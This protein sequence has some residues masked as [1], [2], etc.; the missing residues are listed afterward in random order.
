MLKPSTFA[1][2]A[3]MAEED[4]QFLLSRRLLQVSLLMG[5]V[6]VHASVLATLLPAQQQQP[7]GAAPLLMP[8]AEAALR[9]GCADAAAAAAVL[10]AAPSPPRQLAVAGVPHLLRADLDELLAAREAAAAAAAGMP[11]AAFSARAGLSVRDALFL[12]RRGLFRELDWTGGFGSGA[13]AAALAPGDNEDAGAFAT[14]PTDLVEQLMLV[15]QGDALTPIAKLIGKLDLDLSPDEMATFAAG[16]G[17]HAVTRHGALCFLREDVD[18][19]Y[20]HM[21]S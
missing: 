18:A 15:A 4:V 5:A 6:R 1:A 20:A 19:I 17:F 3:H 9:L 7:G 21:L 16:H 14:V 2:E 13:A 8:L 10:A 11:L 12:L